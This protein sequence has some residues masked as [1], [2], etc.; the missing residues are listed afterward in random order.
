MTFWDHLDELRGVLVRI[1]AVVGVLFVVAFVSMPWLFDRVVM[2]PCNAGF[3]TYRLFDSIASSA[4]FAPEADGAFSVDVVS[5]ELA[6]QF[7]THMSASGWCAIV[8]GFPIVLYMLWGFV[9]PG[10]HENEKR[11]A[12]A[13]FL[14]GNALFYSGVA[15]GYWLVFPLA[16]RFLSQYTLSS[17]IRPIVSLDSYMDNFFMLLLS[18]GAIFEL[19]LLAWMLGKAGLLRR[20]FFKRFRRHAMVVLLVLAAIITPT[21]DP[22][23][24][25][26][27]F[28]PVYMLWEGAAL[29]VPKDSTADDDD[30]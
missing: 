18:M 14:G 26:I 6:S 16:L 20:S 8:V 28:L 1:V 7:F 22:F 27:V 24:L 3:P 12:R 29:L 25:F 23:T 4:G 10:L 9:S 15:L 2:A 5:V 21:G 11:G 19:P 13:A 30:A 17:A